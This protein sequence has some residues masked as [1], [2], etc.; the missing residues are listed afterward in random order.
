MQDSFFNVVPSVKMSDVRQ[1]DGWT[2][3]HLQLC[4]NKEQG[5]H[6]VGT[7]LFIQCSQLEVL[8]RIKDRNARPN[9]NQLITYYLSVSYLL[10]IQQYPVNNTYNIT[11]FQ[12]MNVI[13]KLTIY[14]CSKIYWIWLRFILFSV[15]NVWKNLHGL[16]HKFRMIINVW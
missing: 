6:L 3:Y 2:A 16:L 7:W 15:E 1:L 5:V 10:R 4:R 14:K 12:K 13:Y 8:W 9:N 11:K